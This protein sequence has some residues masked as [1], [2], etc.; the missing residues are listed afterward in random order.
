MFLAG[1]GQSDFRRKWKMCF[2]SEM[3]NW[4]FVEDAKMIFGPHPY[5]VFLARC[6]KLNASWMLTKCVI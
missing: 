4:F 2:S 3:G 5:F 1:D 6:R